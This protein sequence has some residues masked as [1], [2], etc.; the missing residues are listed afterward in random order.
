MN[1][2]KLIGL[3]ENKPQKVAIELPAAVHRDLLAY[4]EILSQESGLSISD[5]AKLIV[6]MVQRFMSTD[7]EFVRRRRQKGGPIK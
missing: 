7:R 4:A 2:L 3:P 1:R 6:P 5:P